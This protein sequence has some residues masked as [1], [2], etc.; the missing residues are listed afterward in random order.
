MSQA[1]IRAG[2]LNAGY[3]NSHVLSGMDFKARQKGT[4][5]IIGPWT[6]CLKIM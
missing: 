1:T 3:A 2:A 6:C 5:V 4:T